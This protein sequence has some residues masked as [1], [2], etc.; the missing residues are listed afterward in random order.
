MLPAQVPAPIWKGREK[1]RRVRGVAGH[2][3]RHPRRPPAAGRAEPRREKAVSFRY[4][5]PDRRTFLPDG[6]QTGFSCAL[7]ATCQLPGALRPGR[8]R[9][10]S[11]SSL[12]FA[13]SSQGAQ[14]LS[15]HDSLKEPL[16][17][18]SPP[19]PTDVLRGGESGP[20][21]GGARPAPAR[22]VTIEKQPP[23]WP[24]FTHSMVQLGRRR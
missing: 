11:L 7:L 13:A 18:G 2:N 15:G 10:P 19:G 23:L 4:Q 17:Y 22:R 5:T 24:R 8:H 1:G 20:E 14:L 16:P 6:F 21:S 12:S 3:L 9:R